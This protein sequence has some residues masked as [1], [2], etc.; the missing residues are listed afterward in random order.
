MTTKTNTASEMLMEVGNYASECFP[1]SNTAITKTKANPKHDYMSWV[2]T[3]C[4]SNRKVKVYVEDGWFE[5]TFFTKN[6]KAS[7]GRVCK[8]R[9][10]RMHELICAFLDGLK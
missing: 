1:F 8:V 6:V 7:S 3:I 2:L 9:Q 10:F 5:F 4:L